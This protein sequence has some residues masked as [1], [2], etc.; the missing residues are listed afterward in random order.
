MSGAIPKAQYFDS[1]GLTVSVRD[2]GAI[3]EGL[4]GSYPANQNVHRLSVAV[5]CLAL[6]TRA[7]ITT[8]FLTTPRASR[9]DIVSHQIL[10]TSCLSTKDT[11]SPAGCLIQFYSCMNVSQR[12]M[13]RR[14]ESKGILL[15][16]NQTM[17]QEEHNGSNLV[18]CAVKC[19]H[20]S[21]C[22]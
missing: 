17:K 4:S 8:E 15:F 3:F 13:A 14:E 22:Q 21:S 6:W 2:Q 9:S 12:A 16:Q 1:K 7:T 19:F 11:L 5:L 20:T 10:R 18:V